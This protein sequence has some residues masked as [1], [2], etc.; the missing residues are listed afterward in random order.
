MVKGTGDHWSTGNE[1]RFLDGIGSF[2]LMKTPREQLLVG[3]LK[4]AFKRN[5]WG[6]IDKDIIISRVKAELG[7]CAGDTCNLCGKEI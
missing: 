4:G 6:H 7:I 2:S 3:Y 1:Q 5:D